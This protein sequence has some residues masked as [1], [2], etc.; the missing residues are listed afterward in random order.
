MI[1]PITIFGEV[2]SAL[3]DFREAE[4]HFG[5]AL[6]ISIEVCMPPYALHTMAG[7]AQLL[8]ALNEKAR[9]YDIVTFVLQQPASWQLSRDSL[10]PLAAELEIEL[11]PEVVVEAQNRARDKTLEGMIEELV[12]TP[13]SQQAPP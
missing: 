9:A 2:A 8:A 3:G 1:E 12:K 4:R 11:P 13:Q 5:R 6:Q 10:K 7:M